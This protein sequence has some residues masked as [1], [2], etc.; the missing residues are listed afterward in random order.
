[1]S[2]TISNILPRGCGYPQIGKGYI[3]ADVDEKGQIAGMP[4]WAFAICPTIS[5]A[6]NFDL[7][8][9]GMDLRERWR[10]AYPGEEAEV[11]VWCIKYVR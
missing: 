3:T 8:R 6:E 11:N 10:M 5:L 4:V 2:T 9:Q 7:S 1:M